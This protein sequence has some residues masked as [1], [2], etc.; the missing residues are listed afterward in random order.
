V[1]SFHIN[2]VGVLHTALTFEKGF[3]F[4]GN[5]YYFLPSLLVIALLIT[6]GAGVLRY[7]KKLER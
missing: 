4:L 7:S 3:N 6:R 5:T 1:T 2:Y